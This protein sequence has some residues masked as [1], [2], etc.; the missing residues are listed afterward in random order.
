L[1]VN[2]VVYAAFV[3]F[4]TGIDCA[5]DVVVAVHWLAD[6]LAGRADVIYGAPQ[7]IYAWV[8]VV[9]LV[10]AFVI[11]AQIVGAG[12]GIVTVGIFGALAVDRSMFTHVIVFVTGVCCAGNVVVAIS[13][14]AY[15]LAGR[16]VVADGTPKT[17]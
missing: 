3:A 13:C 7:I 6:T 5:G 14:L 11:N 17:V 4:G 8:G 10:N 16:T 12:V 9:V 1:A 2:R 15:A